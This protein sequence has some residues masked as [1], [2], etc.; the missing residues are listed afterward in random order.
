[1]V[2]KKKEKKKEEAKLVGVK[3][4]AGLELCYVQCSSVILLGHYVIGF[5]CFC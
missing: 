5:I 2:L 1:V 4:R 3:R